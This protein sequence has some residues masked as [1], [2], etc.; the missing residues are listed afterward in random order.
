MSGHAA[1]TAPNPWQP[2]DGII[3]FK[4]EFLKAA[5]WRIVTCDLSLLRVLPGKSPILIFACACLLVPAYPVAAAP[6]PSPSFAEQ[7]SVTSDAGNFLVSW[8]TQEPVTLEMQ[9]GDGTP[10]TIYSGR[11]HAFF[12]SGLRNGDYAI[13]LKDAAGATADTLILHVQHQ[14]LSR[15]LL[16]VALGALAFLATVAVVLRGARDE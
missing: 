10:R 13:R 15:A 7:D 2:E 11:N 3:F 4:A 14:S 8:N 16:L 6:H 1:R 5:L 9:S 12:L